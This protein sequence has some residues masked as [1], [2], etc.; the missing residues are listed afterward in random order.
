MVMLLLPAFR[1]R[2]VAR[3]DRA[4]GH[5]HAQLGHPD[6]PDRTSS[7]AWHAGLKRDR[8]SRRDS[9]QADHPDRSCSRSGAGDDSAVTHFLLGVDGSGHHGRLDRRHGADPAGPAGHVCGL[10]P[11]Q[12]ANGLK[13]SGLHSCSRLDGCAIDMVR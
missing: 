1:L 4:D 11:G 6:R 2:G 9:L 3:L 5:D 10:V 7:R 13:P 8:R 12:G